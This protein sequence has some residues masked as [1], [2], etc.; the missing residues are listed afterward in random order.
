VRPAGR[1]SR[2]WRWV[3]VAAL[4]L[5]AAVPGPVAAQRAP[6]AVPAL[7]TAGDNLEV[8][9][10]TIGPGR[11]IYERFG[12]NAIWIRDTTTHRD[13]VYNYGDFDF[14]QPDFYRNFALGVPQ[15]WLAV[16]NLD[17]T[18][19]FYQHFQRRVEVQELRLTPAQRAGIANL[20]AIN[21][22]PANR[23]YTYN[24]YSDNCSTRVRDLLDRVLGGAL[25]RATQGKPAD[26]TLRFHTLRSITNNKILYVLIDAGL[27]PR[28]DEPIDQWA[29]MFLPAKVQQRVQELRVPGPGG[30]DLPLV[31]GRATLLDPQVYH[32]LAAPPHWGWAFL[33]IGLAMAM[34]IGLGA[35]DRAV[36][37]AGRVIATLW[38]LTCGLGGLILLFLWFATRHVTSAWNHNLLFLDP[39]A[40]LLIP[41]CW[42]RDGT[43]RWTGQVARLVIGAVVVGAALALAPAIGVQHNGDM[44][45][46]LGP[47]TLAATWLA[48]RGRAGIRAL[49][50]DAG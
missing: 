36:G 12:H 50:L 13:L 35:R 37:A 42:R 9:L 26:G 41:A 32:V 22:E 33:L 34:V 40:V 30:R 15:Y 43:G 23:T 49:P 29:E 17:N 11:A 28:V 14:N 1:R 19:A 24:Y 45:E 2:R 7:R 10:M 47:P 27:G 6:A 39:L 48:L 38:L 46:L 4:G 44:A 20:L 16:D 3:P 5:L 31:I 18:L 25:R 8:F 21:V